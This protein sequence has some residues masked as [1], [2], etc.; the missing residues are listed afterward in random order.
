MLL[1]GGYRVVNII[2]WVVI[3]ITTVWSGIEYFMKNL[4]VF[5]NAK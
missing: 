2:C 4:D 5:R 1:F 3:L